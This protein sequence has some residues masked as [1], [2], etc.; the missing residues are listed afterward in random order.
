MSKTPVYPERS[1]L[2]LDDF[3]DAEFEV[4]TDMDSDI[5]VEAFDDD[6]HLVRW[7]SPEG[8]LLPGKTA[9]MSNEEAARLFSSMVTIRL[10]DERMVMLQRQG[11]IG[12]YIG[13][14]GE[15]AAIIGPAAV[16]EANDWLFPCYRENGAYLL[17]GLPFQRFIDNLF[18]NENDP[19]R[20]RQMPNHIVWAERNITSVSSPI[21]TQIAQAA[22]A[23]HAARLMGKPDV[24]LTYFG[25]G[26][27]SSNDFHTGMNF[28]GVWKAPVVFV[29]R[30]NHWAI[31]VPREK[32]TAAEHF[33]DKAI[34][35]GMPGI[36][37]DGNDL[38][39]MYAVTRDAFA[40]A[41][42]GDG[43][44]M[45]EAVTY[46]LSGHSTSDD[47]RVYRQDSQVEPW[48]AREPFI[49]LRNY[50]TAQ[51]VWSKEREEAL[52]AKVED[53]VKE[54]VARAEAS[55]PPPLDSLFDEVY[56]TLPWHLKEQ[57][58]EVRLLGRTFHGHG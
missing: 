28:A 26:A 18:G 57:R 27:T 19:V 43:P 46:R 44:T 30:N 34:G 33:S 2:E 41:R 36:R 42:R 12:F 40:R 39:A 10:I 49:R 48:K 45:I 29:C 7:L 3:A 9:P 55:E 56:A 37:V 4:D 15:E 11:R 32:Q 38:F 52:R 13:G 54:A 50:L 8:E 53:E 24:M 20:G 16:M 22:G 35:Y 51:G 14:S 23:G 1:S 21:G 17:L 25:E 6:P 47:P 58:E 5:E 31:S